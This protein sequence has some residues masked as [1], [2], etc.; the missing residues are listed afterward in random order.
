MKS[1]I[2]AVVL[3]CVTAVAADRACALVSYDEGRRTI[4]GITLL[5]DVKE[6]DMYYYIPPFPSVAVNDKGELEFLCIG[7]IDAK[8]N[9]SGGIIHFLCEFKLPDEAVKL[10][11][12]A[13]EKEVPGAKLAGVVPLMEPTGEDACSFEIIS[14][15][16]SDTAEGGFTRKV[17]SSG[18]APLTPGSKAAVAAVLNPQGATLLWN[19]LQEPTS[20]IS[21][22]VHAYYEAAVAGYN[23]KVTADVSTVYNHFSSV[24]N[25]QRDY[26]RRQ[27]RNIVDEMVRKS[28]IKIEVTERAGLEIDT[29]SMDNI[30]DLITTKLVELMFDSETG[31]SKLPEKEVGVEQG[32][33]PGRQ[34]ASWFSRTFCGGSGDQQYITDNQ[35]VMKKRE[36]IQTTQF[37]IDLTRRTTIRVPVHTA[38]NMGGIFASFRDDQKVFRVVNLDDPSFEMRDVFFMVD[39]EY[40]AAFQDTINFVSVSFRKKYPES[41]DVTEQLMFTS[42]DI[43]EGRT[44]KAVRY[45]R[46]GITDSSW[47]DYEYRVNWS[48]RDRPTVSLPKGEDDWL[49]ALDSTIALI[50]P[51][52]KLTVNVE[53]DGTEDEFVANGVHSARVEMRWPL[54]GKMRQANKATI[55]YSDGEPRKEFI[56]YYDRDASPEYRVTW[57]ERGGTGR[58]EGPWQKIVAGTN[59][60]EIFLPLPTFAHEGAA[61]GGATSGGATSEGATGTSEASEGGD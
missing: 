4:L 34:Q 10:L 13:L 55:R 12:Q 56:I 27:L 48:V 43:L 46:L 49:S 57:Y 16:L 35:Y 25:V 38:G 17:I 44:S 36:D 8:K 1:L 21:V 50:P 14:A 60:Y 15:V 41:H 32:Q 20:D 26:T 59:E 5:Q 3:L 11:Q 24:I 37:Y 54:V 61:S 33:I 39:N 9:M 2:A 31:L 29:K 19:T 7:F 18:H 22:S 23:A 51:F 58:Q 45:P 52:T 47:L 53:V 28:V 40:T 42:K 30:T 6:P